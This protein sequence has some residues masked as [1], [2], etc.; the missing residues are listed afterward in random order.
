MLGVWGEGGSG[1]LGV[2]AVERGKE[3]RGRGKRKSER[4][5]Y[6]EVVS[7]EGGGGEWGSG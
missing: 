2:G 7:R 4:G 3:G 1:G 6:W 5:E